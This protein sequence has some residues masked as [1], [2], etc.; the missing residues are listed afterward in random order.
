VTKLK[1]S[2][3]TMCAERALAR[4][5]QLTRYPSYSQ[6]RTLFSYM[7]RYLDC[8][9]N[10]AREHPRACRCT[11]FSRAFAPD[12]NGSRFPAIAAALWMFYSS[13]KAAKRNR[14]TP[15]HSRTITCGMDPDSRTIVAIHRG[16]DFRVAVH[17]SSMADWS[18][19]RSEMASQ[20]PYSPD[21][22]KLAINLKGQ[23]DWLK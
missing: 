8:D 12:C 15:S 17:G 6:G 4:G 11:I 20:L 10:A 19:R 2:G 23:T 9:D 16:E 7:G 21:G 1:S 22:K 3:L 18:E 14:L 5:S 13:A